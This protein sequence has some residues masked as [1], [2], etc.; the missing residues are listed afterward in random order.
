MK[1]VLSKLKNVLTKAKR[2]P[3]K[4]KKIPTKFK[5]ILAKGK[6]FVKKTANRFLA[7]PTRV[8]VTYAFL[9]GILLSCAVLSIV[10][11]APHQH[12]YGQVITKAT[13]TTEGYTTYVCEC[14]DKY[15]DNYVSAKGH[16]EIIDAAIAPTCITYGKTEGKHCSVCRKTLVAQ[17][18]IPASHTIGEWTIHTDATCTLDGIKRQGCTVCGAIL[19]TEAIP[20]LGHTVGEWVVDSNATCTKD[21]SRHRA[22]TACG[23]TL[24]T[25]SISKLGHTTSEW[26]IDANATCNEDGQRHQDCTTCGDTLITE[27]IAKLGHTKSEWIID[28]NATCNEDGQRHQDCTTCGDTLVTESIAKL[29]H[30]IGEW[31][32]EKEATCKN[33]G[34]KH[35]L[36]ARCAVST[37]TTVIPALPHAG[38]EW[39]IDTAPTCT[40]AGSKHQ[41]CVACHES[42]NTEEIPA[43]G[44]TEGEWVIDTTPTCTENGSRHLPCAVCQGTILTEEIAPTGHTEGDWVIE[45][46]P[47]CD[48]GGVRCLPCSVCGTVLQTESITKLEHNYTVSLA[49]KVCGDVNKVHTC[50]NCGD[51]YEEQIPPIAIT[52]QIVAKNS[53]TINGYGCYSVEYNV[54]VTGGYGTILVKYELYASISDEE[55]IDA[56]D[57]TLDTVAGV[58]FIDYQSA[59]D[60][61]VYT[62]TAKD[63]AGNISV[64]RFSPINEELI[65]YVHLDNAEHS[66]IDWV[67]TK[68]P[69]CYEYGSK[70]R[71]CSVCG[72]TAYEVMDMAPH[73]VIIDEA[74][75]SNCLQ[76]GL[77]EGSH[78]SVCRLVIVAQVQTPIGGHSYTDKYCICGRFIEEDAVK[79]YDLSP[80]KDGTITGYLTNTENGQKLYI[81]GSGEMKD[82]NNN[83]KSPFANSTIT[84]VYI[85]G[86]VTSVGDYLFSFCHN[87]CEVTIAE[88]VAYIGSRSFETCSSLSKVALPEGLLEIGYSAFN[89]NFKLSDINFPDSLEYI[90]QNAFNQCNISSVLI[91]KNVRYIGS[92]AFAGKNLCK[93]AVDSNNITYYSKNNC[94]IETATKS[95]I[96]GCK[97]SIIPIDG[98]VR[99]IGAYAFAN[100]KIQ[101]VVIPSSVVKIEKYAFSNCDITEI[102]IPGS[103]G[104]IEEYAFLNCTSLTIINCQTSDKPSGWS[105]RWNIITTFPTDQYAKV[106]WS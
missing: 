64:Y 39:V 89:H 69:S 23:D 81:F 40:E 105:D 93:I 10:L 37:Q 5:Q 56:V 26:I 35:L 106:R 78:C 13:C 96:A 87:L 22:C 45:A 12:K 62:I 38:G 59:I 48:E 29:G 51:C 1:N 53:A 103:V 44:H 94:I 77:T 101:S 21:G 49:N 82:F 100:S 9:S 3:S 67:V 27:S 54:T 72:T 42:I 8:H 85:G 47:T 18:I 91:P 36:C 79:I 34:T 32:I 58:T 86:G 98:S 84:E 24:V 104:V 71:C 102:T 74:V 68:A 75:P 80:D 83:N 76:T 30:S 2:V 25:E 11:F 66:Y 65:D 99:C 41:L 43:A 14:G 88:G 60:N 15:T 97:N 95:L 57:F 92:G 55:P 33:E 46:E 73:T 6:A 90:G 20:K 16:A 31:V 70:E 61:Y 28:A 50:S 17:S 19:D 52:L 4:I 63:E 7:L